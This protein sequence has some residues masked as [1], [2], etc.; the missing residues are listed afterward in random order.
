MKTEKEVREE[1]ERINKSKEE[2]NRK[3][4]QM[5]DDVSRDAFINVRMILADKVD[6]LEW[7]LG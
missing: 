5:S 1:I 3:I 4:S 7:V 2:L 6:T